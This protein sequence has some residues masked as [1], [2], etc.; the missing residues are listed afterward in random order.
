[1]KIALVYDLLYPYSI[2]GVEIRNYQLAKFLSKRHEVHLYGVKMWKGNNTINDG[3]LILHGVCRYKDK[4]SFSGNRRISDVLKFSVKLK[5]ELEKEK[6]DLVDCTAFPYF[7]AF[8][9]NDY[10]KR[11]NVP[12]VVTWHEVWDNYWFE[13]LKILGIVGKFIERQ[14]SRL[15][16]N[17][18]VVSRKTGKDLA[19]LNKNKK[20]I[21]GVNNWVDFS[22]IKK[23]KPSKLSS[24]IIFA[25]RHL[26]HKNINI[27]IK[28]LVLVKKKYQKVKLI[29]IG[30]GPETENLKLLTRKLK[31][32]DNVTFFD[33]FKEHSDVIALMKSSKIFVLPSTLEGFGISVIE[34]NACSLPCIVVESEKNAA[35]SLVKNNKTGFVVELNK[36]NIAKKI[37][38]LLDN[39]KKRNEFG[40]E[41]FRFSKQFDEDKVMPKI[42]G[43][44]KG[45]MK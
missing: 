27:L 38:Y 6:F 21:F 5:K 31:L 24:D 39:E 32:Q 15:S 3:K 29:I 23:T 22:E 25:G 43:Y 2:G 19:R 8:V 35:V 7:P 11:N 34:A 18:L 45:L 13:R 44:Y 10:C 33:F 26:K 28:T 14:V 4:Y 41:A 37:I 30:N 20:G 1:M 17:N 42:E 36:W 12:L 9:C 16:K 40:R